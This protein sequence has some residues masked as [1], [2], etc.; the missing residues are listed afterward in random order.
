M[1]PN[2][3]LPPRGRPG[4]ILA[5]EVEGDLAP[6]DFYE[7]A[8]EPG[9]KVNAPALQTPRAVHQRVA[10]LMANGFS[11]AE[12]ALDVGRTIERIRQYRVDPTMQALINHYALQKADLDIE[13]QGRLAREA[14]DVTEIAVREIRTR[15][16]DD[17][18]RAQ[19]PV[20]ELRQ[21]AK[22]FGDRTV[23]P[24]KQAQT[25][26]PVATSITFNIAGRGLLTPSAPTIDHQPAEDASADETNQRAIGSAVGGETKVDPQSSEA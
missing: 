2:D 26:A 24:P 18:K 14:L 13:A 12:I 16:E 25:S 10:L 19:I 1:S 4:A 20:G 17:E 8:T 5:F 15:L 9:V 11:D 23:L 6:S 7:A 3:F 21:I 22:D